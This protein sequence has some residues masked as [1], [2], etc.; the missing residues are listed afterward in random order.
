MLS[1]V[2]PSQHMPASTYLISCIW[3]NVDFVLY[4]FVPGEKEQFFYV[5]F[6]QISV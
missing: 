3:W 2:T 5:I 4:I 6:L 1:W